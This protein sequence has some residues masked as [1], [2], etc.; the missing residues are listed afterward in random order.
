[1]V[2]VIIG[3]DPGRNGGIAVQIIH[4][5]TVVYRMPKDLG[6]LAN[7][8]KGYGEAYKCLA[9]LEK[10]SI[11]PDDV[12]VKGGEK[13]MGKA[14]RIQKMLAGFEA[15][16]TTLTL[17]E[18]P[19][20]MVHPMKWQSALGLRIKGEDKD[21]RKRRYKEVASVM[22]P[23]VRA[24]MWN[25]DALLLCLFGSLMLQKGLGWVAANLPKEYHSK[26]FSD[27]NSII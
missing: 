1:M 15:L 5:K 2:D 11:R 12:T 24:T 27:E 6:E 21:T 19:F 14:F 18:I 10:L 22:F 16:K 26:V 23:T 25:C 20:V 8:L 4:E 9:V 3:I 7:I 13:N 17:L